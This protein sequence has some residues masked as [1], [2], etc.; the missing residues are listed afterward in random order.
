MGIGA[1]RFDVVAAN[2]TRRYG[3]ATIMPVL[4]VVKTVNSQCRRSTRKS[5]DAGLK[6][7]RNASRQ[8]RSIAMDSM[9]PHSTAENH[10]PHLALGPEIAGP[11]DHVE[12]R[13]Q[14]ELGRV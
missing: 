12:K 13:R 11:W 14:G 2:S 4:E 1:R 9:R 10:R 8:L 6:N 5:G 7:V 3:C